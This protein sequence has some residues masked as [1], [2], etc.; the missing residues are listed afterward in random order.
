MR[1]GD[2][3]LSI[4]LE[5]R[6][7]YMFISSPRDSHPNNIKTGRSLP[8]LL[9][10]PTKHTISDTGH[11]NNRTNNDEMLDTILKFPCYHSWSGVQEWAY[12]CTVTP[13]KIFWYLHTLMNHSRAGV[14][15]SHQELPWRQKKESW[16]QKKE[17]PR[18]T[19][20]TQKKKNPTPRKGG[21]FYNRRKR[22]MIRVN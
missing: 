11:I 8:S 3:V 16:D 20:K 22:V 18:I 13:R 2:T 14:H 12:N 6:H 7:H 5:S 15:T 17:T 4:F 1:R 21:L 19:L 9:I 10:H